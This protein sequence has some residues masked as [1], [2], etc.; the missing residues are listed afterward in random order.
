MNAGA[1]ESLCEKERHPSC[2][3][4]HFQNMDF[5]LLVLISFEVATVTT[6]DSQEHPTCCD[7]SYLLGS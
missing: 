1:Y 6:M 3:K 4:S 5:N 7:N 2:V